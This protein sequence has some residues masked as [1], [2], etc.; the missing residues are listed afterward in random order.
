M[1]FLTWFLGLFDSAPATPA[2]AQEQIND[3][4]VLLRAYPK[5]VEGTE[6]TCP[7]CGELLLTA[8]RDIYYGSRMSSDDWE[9]AEAYGLI[10]H[11]H[12]GWRTMR[13]EPVTGRTQIHTPTGWVG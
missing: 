11:Q 7:A 5:F 9:G 1:R 2:C 8:K 13:V 10:P 4:K 12:C 6:W 3:R